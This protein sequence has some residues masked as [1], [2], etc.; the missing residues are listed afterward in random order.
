MESFEYYANFLMGM[1]SP[2]DRKWTDRV[3]YHTPTSDIE[4]V[5]QFMEE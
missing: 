1:R 2:S 5:D 4:K 3:E